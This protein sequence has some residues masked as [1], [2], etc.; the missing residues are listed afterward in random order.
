M[1]D[2]QSTS[3]RER[4]KMVKWLQLL[5]IRLELITRKPQEKPYQEKQKSTTE[6]T[7]VEQGM[8]EYPTSELSPK[9]RMWD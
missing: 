5:A 2:V 9:V 3:L 4:R 7:K 8:T 6:T 1:V